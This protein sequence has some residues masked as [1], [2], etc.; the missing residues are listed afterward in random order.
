VGSVTLIADQPIRVGDFCKVGQ[1]LGTVEQIGM[2]STRLRT[3]DRTIVTIPNGEFSSLQIEN[4]AHRDRF[5]FAPK[6]RLHFSTTPAQMRSL[7]AELRTLLTATP[8]VDP[9]PARVRFIGIGENS[10][11]V[12]VFSYILADDFNEYLEIQEDLLLRMMD[13]VATRGKGFALP[14]QTLYLDRDN[15]L[16]GP[17]DQAV[18]APDGHGQKPENP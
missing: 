5:L 13:L 12:E 9:D 16:A 11:D 6:L 2:R 15:G 10:L 1:T 7:L 3:N 18:P 8:K 14:S 17:K 4:F